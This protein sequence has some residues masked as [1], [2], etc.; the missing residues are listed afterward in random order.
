ML[1]RTQSSSLRGEARPLTGPSHRPATAEKSVIGTGEATDCGDVPAQPP[2]AT[3]PAATSAATPCATRR[4]RSRRAASLSIPEPTSLG[5]RQ[6]AIVPILRPARL[7]LLGADRALLAVRDERESARVD[8]L[9]H[10]I[11]HRR[12]GPAL[13]Q[14]QVV[15]GGPALVTVALDQHEL[16]GI[17]L[18]VRRAGVEDLGVARTDVR[19]VEVEI[20]VLQRGVRHV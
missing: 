9:R 4:Q 2:M 18:E 15:L 17:R 7:G 6:E 12:L 5:L 1:S 10:E 16:V 13:A 3:A 8:A 11:V 20:D 14:R 19:L